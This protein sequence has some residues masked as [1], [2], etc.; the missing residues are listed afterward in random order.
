MTVIISGKVHI[1]GGDW[2]GVFFVVLHLLL[3]GALHCQ[4]S[5]LPVKIILDG[6]RRVANQLLQGSADHFQAPN[7]SIFRKRYIG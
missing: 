6:V 3:R 1:F 5:D 2:R 7:E 4:S